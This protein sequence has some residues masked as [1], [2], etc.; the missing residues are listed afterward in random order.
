MDT[1]GFRAVGTSVTTLYDRFYIASNREYVSY[2]KYLKSGPYNFGFPNR[3]DWVEHFPYQD[4]LLVSLWD[5]S[6]TNNNTSQHP[7]EG[8]ILPI[9]S[10]PEVIYRLDGKPWRGRI[11]TY[12]APFS[13]QKADSFT[14]HAQET[15]QAS[16]I[17]GQAA[18]PLFDDTRSYWRAALPRVG[19]NTPGVGVTMRVVQENETSVRV[20][21]GGTAPR[22]AAVAA[23]RT[24]EAAQAAN[25]AANAKPR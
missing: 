8:Q 5:T 15:G 25:T 16:Y 4:G 1:G 17:R 14:L 3:P 18:Q 6:Q 21:I 9:D 11:Q 24:V 19:V 10:H 12:D 22:P 20:R 2:D 23:A 7:G 13:L